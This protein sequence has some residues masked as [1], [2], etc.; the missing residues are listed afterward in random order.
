VLLWLDDQIR[1]VPSELHGRRRLIYLPA[2]VAN[3]LT[4]RPGE[5]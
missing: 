4:S 1:N 2:R 3:I 5:S